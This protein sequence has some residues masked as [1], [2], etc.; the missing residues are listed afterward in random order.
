MTAKEF[1]DKA[2]HQLKSQG[3]TITELADLIGI[4]RNTLYSQR[5]N[6]YLPKVNQIKKMEDVLKCK[7]FDEDD[8]C[9]EFLPYLRQ[10]EKW[11]L[12][13]VRQILNMPEPVSQK[14]GNHTAKVN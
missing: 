10:A 7:F 1:W 13:S 5:K 6:G 3:V 9:L 14:D 11:Q 4:S 8:S 2:N 12:K